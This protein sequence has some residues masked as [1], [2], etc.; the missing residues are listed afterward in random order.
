M[1]TIRDNFIKDEKLLRDIANDNTFFADPVLIN[2]SAT[3][4]A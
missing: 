1:I 3:E 4:S 2:L